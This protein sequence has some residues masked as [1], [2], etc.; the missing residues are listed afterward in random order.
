M[1]LEG[2]Q[3]HPN[4]LFYLKVDLFHLNNCYAFFFRCLKNPKWAYIYAY[5][6]DTEI[7][8]EFRVSMSD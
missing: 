2:V 8:V 1:C 4:L 3:N 5:I 6:D 7:L